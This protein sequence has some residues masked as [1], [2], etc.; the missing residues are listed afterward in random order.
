M[1]SPRTGTCLNFERHV[2][3]AL[4]DVA[5]LVP[6]ASEGRGRGNAFLADLAGC[7]A[8]IQVVDG[9]AATDVEGNPISP[10]TD[11]AT[12]AASIA[13]E[14]TFLT[15]ELEQWIA[16]VLATAGPEAFVVS[17]RKVSEA[18]WASS[19]SA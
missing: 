7:D 2:P 10:A 16:S 8:L 15:T 5:G 1:C 11:P 9:A 14:V 6:G 18:C 19:L 4:V 13:H 17:K 3:V 12:A